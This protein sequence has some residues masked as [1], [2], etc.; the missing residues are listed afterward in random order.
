MLIST[1]YSLLP[2]KTSCNNGE[3]LF[4][5]AVS[6]MSNALNQLNYVKFLNRVN[7]PIM[8]STYTPALT[9]SGRDYMNAKVSPSQGLITKGYTESHKLIS[10]TRLVSDWIGVV[11][12][13]ESGST[14]QDAGSSAFAPVIDV[15]IGLLN[16]SG[17][18]YSQVAVVDYGIRFNSAD[19]LELSSETST[20]IGSSYMVDSG[21]IIP[22]AVP[23]NTSPEAPRPLYIPN[24]VGVYQA[25]G[26]RVVFNISCT[27]CKLKA[28]STFDLYKADRS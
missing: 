19:S 28:F 9:A 22:A 3:I 5:S 2:N 24:T 11:I 27:D 12:Q 16:D 14:S 6:S 25:R 1:A 8:R 17:S 15:E 26:E 23:T 18:G 21:Y 4:G 20:Q 13:Y 7:Y 10:A